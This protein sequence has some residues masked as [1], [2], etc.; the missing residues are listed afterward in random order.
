MSAGFGETGYLIDQPTKRRLGALDV[1]C[2]G[3]SATRTK[4]LPRKDSES[5]NIPVQNEGQEGF[6]AVSSTEAG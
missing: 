6:K 2:Y 3:E 5:M 1:H 4:S